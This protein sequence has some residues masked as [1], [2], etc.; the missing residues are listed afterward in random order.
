[1]P[2]RLGIPTLQSASPF[3]SELPHG[4]VPDRL[5][6]HKRPARRRAP[7]TRSFYYDPG[8]GRSLRWHRNHQLTI[9]ERTHLRRLPALIGLLS[10]NAG[11]V[12][13]IAHDRWFLE[14]IATHI[15]A[16]EASPGSPSSTAPRG[17]AGWVTRRALQCRRPELRRLGGGCA[18]RSPIAARRSRHFSEYEEWRRTPRRRCRHPPAPDHLPQSDEVTVHTVHFA[19]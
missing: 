19:Q 6:L 3:E 11:C 1:M 4:C 8:Q 13:G 14:R 16:F 9:F 5:L 15:L 18:K 12:V 10:A 7:P 2:P 17:G